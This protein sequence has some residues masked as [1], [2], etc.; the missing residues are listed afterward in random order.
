MGLS[1][2]LAWA[3]CISTDRDFISSEGVGDLTWLAWA[4]AKAMASG[5]SLYRSCSIPYITNMALS[6]HQ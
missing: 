6:L 1:E 4:W 3:S 5:G 2:L